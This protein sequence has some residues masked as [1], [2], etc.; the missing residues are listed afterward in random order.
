MQCEKDLTAIASFEN[1]GRESQA[2]ECGEHLEGKV[3]K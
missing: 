3:R 1:E 2:E